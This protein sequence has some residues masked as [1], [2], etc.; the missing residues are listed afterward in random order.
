L[1]SIIPEP[2]R[3]RSFLTSAAVKLD[4]FLSRF[5]V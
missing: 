4:I 2:V 5:G 3:S 1:Q